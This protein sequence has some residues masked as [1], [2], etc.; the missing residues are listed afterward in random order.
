MGDACDTM[1]STDHHQSG[2]EDSGGRE[3][4]VPTN[5]SGL[6]RTRSGRLVRSNAAPPEDGPSEGRTRPTWSKIALGAVALA[7]LVGFVAFLA[8]SSPR[9]T[10]ASLESILEDVGF[11]IREQ[12]GPRLNR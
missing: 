5:P 1:D 7:S 10:K 8:D 12:K 11:V 2:V 9:R 6:V 3:A 4:H